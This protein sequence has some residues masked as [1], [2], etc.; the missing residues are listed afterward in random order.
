MNKPVSNA[1]WCGSD[2]FAYRPALVGGVQISSIK[3]FVA[4]WTFRN[5]ILSFCKSFEITKHKVEAMTVL[6]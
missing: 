4:N 3:T 6:N 2:E 1:E 5:Q